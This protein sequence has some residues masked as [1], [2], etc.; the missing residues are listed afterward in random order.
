MARDSMPQEV[1]EL[2]K[3]YV[4]RLIDPRNGETFYVGK[5]V[6]DRVFV[7][8]R[9]EAT[10]LAQDEEEQ[11]VDPKL[12]R[13]RE[14]KDAGLEVAHI[15]HR[16]GLPSHVALEVEAALIDAYPGLTNKVKGHRSGERGSRHVEEIITEYEAEEFEVREPLLMI[17]VGVFYYQREA[18]DDPAYDAARYAWPV[19]LGRAKSRNLVLVRV[20]GMVRGAYRPTE[21]LP[22]T[23]ENFPDLAKTYNDV[24][25]IPGF[26]GFVGE[27]AEPEVWNYYV[28]KR[29][30]KR[31]ISQTAFRYLDPGA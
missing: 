1:A 14:I 17:S 23:R 27:K 28:G 26:Y 5:G 8:A 29:V 11:I 15:I 21:W 25:D 2:L 22:A 24:A 12:Y 7:H 20:R 19:S 3:H 6:G 18:S 16:H 31:F 10:A 9:G 4:Y 13:I 30:P